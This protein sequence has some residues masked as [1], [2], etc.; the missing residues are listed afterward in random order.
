MR[1]SNILITIISIYLVG[2][3]SSNTNYEQEGK[4]PLLIQCDASEP[5]SVCHKAAEE[6]CPK[7]YTTLSEKSGDPKE[8]RVQCHQ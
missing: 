1:K 8:L 4:E 5:F 3:A 6:E 7:G 2:C